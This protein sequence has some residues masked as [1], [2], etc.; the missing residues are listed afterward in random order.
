MYVNIE[1]AEGDGLAVSHARPSHVVAGRGHL[2]SPLWHS[3][4][5]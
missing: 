4:L 1:A 5:D 3:Q 2:E